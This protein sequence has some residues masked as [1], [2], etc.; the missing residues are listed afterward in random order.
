[1]VV[2]EEV[3]DRY[4]IHKEIDVVENLLEPVYKCF[5]KYGYYP[6]ISHIILSRD[7]AKYP[8]PLYLDLVFDHKILYDKDLCVK[9]LGER[10]THIFHNR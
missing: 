3:E 10:K 7:Q 5:K 2:L 6:H 8:R 4:L 1:L 9:S